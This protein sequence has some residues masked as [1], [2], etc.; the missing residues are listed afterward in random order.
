MLIEQFDARTNSRILDSSNVIFFY[1]EFSETMKIIYK[2]Y[3]F[4]LANIWTSLNIAI[5]SFL[6]HFSRDLYIILDLIRLVDILIFC[7]ASSGRWLYL[8]VWS[9]SLS[10]WTCLRSISIIRVVGWP[11]SRY[12]FSHSN[13]S[14]RFLVFT[15]LD[16]MF[17]F[18][19]FFSVSHLFLVSWVTYADS[20]KIEL[21]FRWMWYFTEYSLNASKYPHSLTPSLPIQMYEHW[22]HWCAVENSSRAWRVSD[23]GW[24]RVEKESKSKQS[25][26]WA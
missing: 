13:V 9:S 21:W 22:E 20:K 8:C 23:G 25:L 10:D 7:V 6:L 19:M 3:R 1:C 12:I 11:N 5:F 24:T 4:Y 16:F 15:F 17:I 14:M 2:I 26:C 18:P